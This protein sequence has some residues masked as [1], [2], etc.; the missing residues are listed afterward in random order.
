MLELPRP[1]IPPVAGSRYRLHVESSADLGR[2]A[3]AGELTLDALGR[4]S[5]LATGQG[6]HGFFRL[7]AELVGGASEAVDGAEVFGFATVFDEALARIGFLTP[8]AFAG[9]ARDAAPNYLETL[10]F[11]PTT[12]KYWHLFDAN[13]SVA[14]AGKLT[15]GPGWRT[16]DFRLNEAERAVFLKNGFVVSERLGAALRPYADPSTFAALF[17][18]IFN[19]DLPVFISADCVLHAWHY[20]CAHMLSELEELVL[21]PELESI[22]DRVQAPLATWAVT[23]GLGEPMTTA[24]NDALGYVEVGRSLIKGQPTAPGV[25]E[26]LAAIDRGA[27]S[28]FPVAGS[29]REVD[30]SQFAP[31]SYYTRS[32][33]LRRYFRAYQWLSRIDFRVFDPEDPEG[34]LRQLAIASALSLALKDTGSV[35]AWETVD[36]AIR[37]FVGRVDAMGFSHLLP[38]LAAAQIDE[39]ADLGSREALRSLQERILDGNLGAQLIPGDVHSTPA[40]PEVAQLPNTFVFAGQRFVLDSWALARVTFDRIP[41]NEDVPGV[42]YSRKVLR[43]MPSGLDVAYSVLGNTAIGSE[44]ARR[45]QGPPAPGQFRDGFPYAHV[46]EAVRE[47]TGALRPE[48]WEDTLYMRW[49]WALRALSEPTTDAKFPEAMRTRAW[50]MRTLNTQMASYSELKHDT[51]LYGKQPYTASILC[52]YPAGFVEPV[53]DFWRRM[54]GMARAAKAIADGWSPEVRQRVVVVRKELEWGG[55]EE[56]PVHVGSR[57]ADQSLHL[58]RFASTQL[59]LATLAQKEL[60]QQPFTEAETLFIRSLM[61]DR[62]LDYGGARYDGWYPKL[63]YTDFSMV[64]MTSDRTGSN[65]RDALI[66]DIHTAPPD[67]VDPIGG[68]LHLATGDVDLLLI[69]VDNGPDRAVYAGPVMSHYEFLAPGPQMKRW[70]DEGWKAALD[71]RQAPARPEW[72][73]GY[74]VP[75]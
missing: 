53:P 21:A 10:T 65:E 67:E 16:Y 44:L 40:G 24:V 11:D 29:P 60:D 6:T 66:A 64:S 22:L 30:F 69:A 36:R 47:T 23:P 61:N 46:L 72:T 26:A 55:V 5:A 15:N 17:Y 8:E 4:W 48:A 28:T 63:Y 59:A 7:R 32:A 71:A 56:T 57:L 70:T 20:T 52:E 54:E 37:L 38:L 27:I 12:A 39:P 50:A 73:R 75:R 51:L 68:I 35:A 74:L 25:A 33:G 19:D 34:S 1:P 9:Q 45:M 3:P 31:R 18:R 43:R 13:P 14:N 41:W 49:L 58:D 62:T 2:W 42:T